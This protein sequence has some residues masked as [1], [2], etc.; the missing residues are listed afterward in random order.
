MPSSEPTDVIIS[1]FGS[2]PQSVQAKFQRPT[3]FLDMPVP[4]GQ[5][6]GDQAQSFGWPHPLRGILKK[7]GVTKPKRV[8]VFGFS[9]GCQGVISLLK[10]QD[11]G[12]IEH[13]MMF[14]GLHCSWYPGIGPNEGRS[15]IEGTC[16]GAATAFAELAA[17]GP[18]AIGGNP[19]GQ[20]YF[21]LTHSSVIPPNYPATFDTAREIIARLWEDAP[22]ADL[23]PGTV[24]MTFDPPWIAKGIKYT[25]DTI[26]YAVGQNGLTIMGYNNID[27][28]GAADHIYQGNIVLKTVLEKL[29]APRWNDVD[30]SAPACTGSGTMGAAACNPSAPVTIPDDF[31]EH[32][33]DASIDFLKWAGEVQEKPSISVGG[34]FASALIGSGVGLG[35]AEIVKLLKRRWA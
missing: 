32:P 14:D 20:H 25:Q 11:A 6:Y 24:G 28:A 9:Q 16:L 33:D 10:S 29:L 35:L 27:P 22:E 19:P 4:E 21:T 2:V 34:L 30:P 12:Y 13:A 7:F 1:W 31:F 18:V 15:N 8:A 23:P 3:R 17:K 26:R 5:H